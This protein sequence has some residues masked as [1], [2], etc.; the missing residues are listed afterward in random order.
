MRVHQKGNEV[1][2]QELYCELD[3][4]M[5]HARRILQNAQSELYCEP[6]NAMM[7]AREILQNAQARA[8][9]KFIALGWEIEREEKLL[10]NRE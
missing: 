5:T 7:H 6:D 9:E 1:T 10:A 2:Y 3:N 4:A 8:G